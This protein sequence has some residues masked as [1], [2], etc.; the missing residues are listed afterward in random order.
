[1][2]AAA[3]R[4]QRF[5]RRVRESRKLYGR[6]VTGFMIFYIIIDIWTG[7][8]LSWVPD[9]DGPNLLRDNPLFAFLGVLVIPTAMLLTIV[10]ALWVYDNERQLNGLNWTRRVWGAIFLLVATFVALSFTPDAGGLGAIPLI[11]LGFCWLVGRYFN[12]N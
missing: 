12:K 4:R 3:T 10:G 9:G 8:L 5:V 6:L 7:F 11:G 1:M 2:S